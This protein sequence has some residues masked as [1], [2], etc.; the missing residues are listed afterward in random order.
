MVADCMTIAARVKAVRED[1]V[2]F[3]NDGIYGALAE[4]PVMG[5]TDR[6]AVLDPAGRPRM[7][8]VR[9]RIVFGPTCDSL[10][11]L[12][13]EIALPGDIAEGDY[14][15]VGGI[16]AY[17]TATLTRFNGYGDLRVVTVETLG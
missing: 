5:M 15:L 4:M 1:G 13:G 3:L 10:D 14:V 12:P 7:G 16:G 6:V 8:E 2:V 17:S 11:R 9:P